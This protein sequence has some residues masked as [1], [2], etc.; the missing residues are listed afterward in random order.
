MQVGIP[1]DKTGAPE[2]PAD[3]ADDVSAYFENAYGL[4]DPDFNEFEQSFVV[5]VKGKNPVARAWQLCQQV[6]NSIYLLHP[7]TRSLII[8]CDDAL[9]RKLGPEG[10]AAVNLELFSRLEELIERRLVRAPTIS[11]TPD[12]AEEMASLL[13]AGLHHV[14]RECFYSADDSVKLRYIDRSKHL[15]TEEERLEA[16]RQ[17]AEKDKVAIPLTFWIRKCAEKK[18]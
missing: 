17:V 5:V 6:E 18:Q 14:S 7:T 4:K 15:P 12:D 9:L 1:R 3:W 11:G 13:K 2:P 16:Y 8:T 10:M